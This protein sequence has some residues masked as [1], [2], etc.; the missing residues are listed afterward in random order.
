[1]KK[2]EQEKPKF[3]HGG[4]REGSGRK[5]RTGVETRVRGFRLRQDV[6]DMLEPIE[7]KSTFLEQAI[8]DKL[9]KD[10]II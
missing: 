10:G 1:M 4:R 5:K 7:D 6:L 8:V 9:R 3:T 2:E